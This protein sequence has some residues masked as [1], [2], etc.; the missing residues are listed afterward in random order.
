MI[1]LP[2]TDH[3]RVC[4]A[5]SFSYLHHHDAVRSLDGGQPVRDEDDGATYPGRVEGVL[6]EPLALRVQRRGGFVEQ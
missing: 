6:D 4:F 3:D 1:P 5:F 2:H